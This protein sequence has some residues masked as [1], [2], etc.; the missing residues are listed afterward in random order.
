MYTANPVK[1]TGKGIGDLNH[2][3]GMGSES[4]RERDAYRVL[5]WKKE[6]AARLYHVP[7]SFRV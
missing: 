1:Q 7:M 3:N 6:K 4:E 5:V 2:L